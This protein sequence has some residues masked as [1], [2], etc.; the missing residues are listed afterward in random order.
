MNK[1]AETWVLTMVAVAGCGTEDISTAP[2][3]GSVG[4]QPWTF[5]AGHTSAFL[6]Q[7]EDD[8]FASLYPTVFM[9]CS[10]SGSSGPYLIVSIPKQVGD[11]DFNF[12]RNMTFVTSN[13][14]NLVTFDGRIVV[15]EVSATHV[16]GGLYGSY[17][18]DNEVNGQFDVTVC[19]DQ[20]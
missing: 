3:T 17:D 6:S 19:T 8:F 20:T 12:G 18:G 10:F 16:S 4:G 5:Q 1:L 15:D 11:Y 2:L 9:P 13:N 14:D 7:G